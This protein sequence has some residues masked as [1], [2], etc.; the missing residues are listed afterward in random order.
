MKSQV[1]ILTIHPPISSKLL[2]RYRFT[3][4]VYIVRQK[5]QVLYIGDSVNIYKSGL[6][7]FQKGGVL[8][9]I[10]IHN[11]TFEIIFSPIRLGSVED[12]L[13]QHF[14]PPYNYIRKRPVLLSKYE[15]K[16]IQ[17][18][19]QHYFKHSRFFAAASNA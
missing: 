10:P 12:A 15:K 7:L 8:S 5:E 6:R 18:I 4:G 13:K 19:K 2:G 16:Q 11:I 1:E 17:R 3:K 9:H 14:L